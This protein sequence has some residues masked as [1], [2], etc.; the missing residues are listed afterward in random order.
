[1]KSLIMICHLAFT[2]NA[3][4]QKETFFVFDR[5]WKETEIKK[6]VFLIQL[7][8]FNDTT[9]EWN[10]YNMY[11]PMIKSERTKARD[12]DDPHG[13]AIYYD[14]Q[15]YID[16]MG[17]YEK[18]LKHGRWTICGDTGKY[19]RFEDYHKG[20]LTAV[21][22]IKTKDSLQ[23]K[24]EF[25]D[26]RNSEY[27]GALSGWQKFLNKNLKYPDRAVNIEAE[28]IVRISFTIDIE[29]NVIEPFISK[30]VE[31]SLDN[32]ALRIIKKTPKWIPAFQNGKFIRSYKI[33]PIVF[34]LK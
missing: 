6:A 13:R 15:G 21:E 23:Y 8:T 5:D 19:L 30:T 2:L 34:R 14:S 7:K 31:Y 26:E 24:K 29:G 28:G 33:Q 4:G 20:I 27:P 32:E 11:G 18:G 9:W 16:S 17:T 12:D 25:P 22:Q 10:Y 3:F 1:M